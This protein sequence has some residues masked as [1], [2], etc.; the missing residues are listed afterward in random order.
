MTEIETADDGWTT[1]QSALL[2]AVRDV[3][4]AEL[5][6]AADHAGRALVRL[7]ALELG[8][9][10]PEPVERDGGLVNMIYGKPITTETGPRGMQSRPI[11]DQPQA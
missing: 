3:A 8:H 4:L 2:D 1:V 9:P 5:A 10:L 6:P 11:R 7:L